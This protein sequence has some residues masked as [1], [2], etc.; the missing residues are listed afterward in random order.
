MLTNSAIA[1]ASVILAG[2]A[3]AQ[4]FPIPQTATQISG[5]APGTAMTKACVVVVPESLVH[6][7]TCI[8]SAAGG[9]FGL[10]QGS[11]GGA[12]PMR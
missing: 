2:N 4:Q 12:Y 7:F 8:G 3:G 1:C 9:N 11:E 6:C 5:P 10:R